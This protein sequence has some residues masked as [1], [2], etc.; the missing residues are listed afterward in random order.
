MRSPHL[1]L[2]AGA[3]TLGL[4]LAACGGGGDG[5]SGEPAP[6]TAV[7]AD[8]RLAPG[9]VAV[10]GA[11]AETRL[12]D[13]TVAA[14]VNVAQ[15]YVDTAVLGPV[16]EGEVADG[17]AALFEDALRERATTTDAAA[18]TDAGVPRATERPDVDATPV[19][20]DALADPAGSVVLLGTTFEVDV[21]V[22][23]ASGTY[24]LHR[25]GELT[26]AP[27]PD[28]GWLVTGYRMVVTR[29]LPEGPPATTAAEAGA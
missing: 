18:L 7:R 12:D 25:S 14:A 10:H 26:L 23:A 21:R 22:P 2:L 4:A 13:A 6:T 27:G 28:G 29:D 11:G 1:R 3:A 20:I 19:R 15:R 8:A 9:E 5:E 17:F 24:G 16:V